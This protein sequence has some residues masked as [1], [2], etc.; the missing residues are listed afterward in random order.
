MKSAK[1]TPAELIIR[2][3]VESAINAVKPSIL[4]E[5]N[6]YIVSDTLHAFGTQVA[7]EPGAGVRCVAIGKSAEAMA[8]EVRRKLGKR[9]SGII[10]TPFERHMGVDGFECFRTG[11]PIPDDE[12]VRAGRAVLDF[13]AAAHAEDLILFLVSGGGSAS[14]FVPVEGIALSDA[15]LLIKLLFDDGVSIDKVNLVRR[16]L[17][18]LGGGKLSAAAPGKKKLSLVIS[19]VVGDDPASIASGP[20]VND[21]STPADAVRFLEERGLIARVPEAVRAAFLRHQEVE[22]VPV[23]AEGTVVVIASNRNALDAAK[24]TGIGK[25]LN[26]LV[27]TR[28]WESDVDDTAKAIVSIARSI[29]SESLPVSPPALLLVGGETT[30]RVA[31]SGKGGRN[32]Q[33]VL[34]ALLQLVELERIGTRL[35]RSTVFSFG[36][37]GKD[38]TSDAAGALASLGTIEGVTAKKGIIEDCLQRN[39]SNSFFAQYGGLIET[40]PTDTNVMDVFGVVVI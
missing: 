15:N 26:T 6:F 5:S 4:F 11:H 2:G 19:D 38:G 23:L 9:V 22:G 31:G 37:D 28:Y 34:S 12:S 25:H 21:E 20:T 33:L 29:E 40:G 30:V 35:G 3:V 10:A 36:T 39:D 32:Q 24:K 13:V 17:S 8:N 14:V 16:H 18:R 1:N 7:L 27:L